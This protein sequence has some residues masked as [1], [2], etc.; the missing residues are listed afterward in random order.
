MS[1]RPYLQ[2]SIRELEY[3]FMINRNNTEVCRNL[4]HEL[5]F[6][7]T[8]RALRLQREIASANVP[9]KSPAN[10]ASGDNWQT[11]RVTPPSS[12]PPEPPPPPANG[13]PPRPVNRP[14]PKPPV[15]DRPEDILR[16][17]TALEVLSPQGYRRETDMTG[18]DPRRIAR[19]DDSALPWEV[20][21][22]SRPGKRLF[23]ELML[24]TI[25]LG[26][27]VEAL[28]KLYADSRPDAP[29]VTQRSPI[30]SILLDKNGCPLEEETSLAISSFAWGVPIALKG[31]LKL[32]ADWPVEERRLVR[33]FRERLIRRNK[34]GD[35]LPLTKAAVAR[36]Y[37]HLVA[38]LQLSGHDIRPPHFV[39]RRYEFFASK[40]P[41]EPSLLNSFFL[42]DL[43]AAREMS[44][45]GRLPHALKFYLG[46]STPETRTDL[47]QDEVGLQYLL[48]PAL[49][50]PGRWPGKGRFPLA[51]LQQAAVNATT[52]G[53]KETGILSVNGP[54]GTGKT[55]LLRDIVAAR[56]VERA[57]VMAG[58][59]DP[60]GAFSP[61]GQVLQRSGAKIT[62]HRLDDR[63][64][65]FE[66]VVASS[67]NKAVENVSAELPVLD[68]VA[69][70]AA[71]LRYFKSI[72]DT[73][74]ERDT[75]GMIAAVLG[76]ASNRYLFS[77]AFWRDEENGLSTYLNHAAGVPQ[78]T[79][80]PQKDGPPLKRLKTV[81]VAERPP[82]GR[83]EALRR[84]EG[85]RASFVEAWN[86]SRQALA[87]L[88]EIHKELVRLA[89]IASEITETGT[90]IPLLEQDIGDTE[91]GYYETLARKDKAKAELEEVVDVLAIHRE[92][93]PGFLARLF[94]T[95]SAKDW[96]LQHGRISE[97][98]RGNAAILQSC[99]DALENLKRE[100]AAKTALLKDKT[101][102]LARRKE[103]HQRLGARVSGLCAPLGV[104]VPDDA[105]FSRRHE[106]IQTA[107]VWFDRA[108]Q[109]RRDRLFEKAMALHRAFM[110]CASDALRQNLSI[111]LETFG[112]RSFGTSEKDALLSDLWAS[113][114]LV[115]PV[116]S[117]TFA[118]VHRMFSRLPPET[119][120]WLLV[121]EAGQAI[122]Q[123]AVGAIMRSKR[124]VVVG[125]PLQIEP[126]VTL[127]SSLTEEICAF[128]GVD[129][130]KYNAPEASVQTIADRSSAYCARF[131]TGSGHR[132][133][134]APLLVHRRCDSP[135]F[136][137]SNE[138]AYS[139]LMVQAKKPSGGALPLGRSCWFD[140][141]GR[142]GPDK[143]CAD[144]AEKLMELLRALRGKGAAP[145]LYIVTP[146]VIVQD[147][148]RR[149]LV[150]SRILNGWTD[151][152]D[153]WVWDHVGTVHTVQGREA[154]TVFFVLGAQSPSQRGAREW[155]GRRPNLANVAV[156]R[157][158]SS[159]YVIGNRELWKSA[160]V[161]AT[162]AQMLP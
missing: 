72:S 25:N 148:L 137:I 40:V 81:I 161:F 91:T 102:H 94:G 117:T 149:H 61:T 47:L 134:G 144:E 16:A 119:L 121:D 100:R 131:P 10:P 58:Y 42:E 128:F 122:P 118:S 127:P 92:K 115:V 78:F 152:P 85:A 48:Q 53:L 41:P 50:P 68:A 88:Q 129:A 126:V 11:A 69:E 125:D 83:R 27:A 22:K 162:V 87:D 19:L 3:I 150:D 1:A 7:S 66:M 120:G 57:A 12:P 82:E 136:D 93:K 37:A 145:D 86:A 123:A 64:K 158:K 5:E 20:G 71:D 146:F 104:P 90:Q 138:I 116:V 77:Q 141:V 39:L 112:T 111:F 8:Q 160:G 52:G 103:E 101:E 32:L 73:V 33:A 140:V 62:L 24:G 95:H 157:A 59:K 75:W 135:M 130:L 36:L 31:D 60:A 28:L 84:W 79:M 151:N 108:K 65:G 30:A 6:R 35:I 55:T 96:R 98:H 110:D 153:S 155:A 124:S 2:K 142:P 46:V 99:E 147:N 107:S 109:T 17:W 38:A 29:S 44:R 45:T 18:G 154:E 23:Y 76:N 97:R 70:D 43:A 13:V 80:E 143:W 51:L 14:G 74:L 105:F 106:D 56:V 67:N 34:D 15:T 132:D 114:F 159:L 49:T 4:L 89:E 63:L 9:G 54:P 113:F 139:N 133:V 26:P 21:E 156:T